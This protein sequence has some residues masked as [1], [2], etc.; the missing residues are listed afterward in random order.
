MAL[1]D[2][3]LSFNKK[4]IQL[5]VVNVEHGIRGDESLRDSEFVKNYCQ[6]HGL[7]LFF[8]S[9]D[10]L[11]YA[12]ENSLSVEQAARELRLGFFRSL[13]TDGKTDYVAF[14]HHLD[15]VCET[16]LMRTFRGTGVDGLVGIKQSDI[17][18][19]PLL[20]V[21]RKQI[22]DYVKE[23]NIPFIEDSTNADSAY[24]RNFLRNEILPRI[25]QRWDY[26]K[27][28]LT[29]TKNAAEVVELLDSLSIKPE[30]VDFDAYA[31]DLNELEKLPKAVKKHSIRRAVALLNG[32]VDFER[33]NLE[34]VLD[35][36]TKRNGAS[37][38]L[39]G[40][41]KVWKEYDKLTFER[42]I[43]FD[44]REIPFNVGTLKFDT[45]KWTIVE[46]TDERLRFDLSKIPKN[47]VIRGM[48][49]GDVFCKFGGFTKPLGD[50]YTDKKVPLRL[51]RRLPVIASDNEILVTVFEISEKVKVDRGGYTIK[52]L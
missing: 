21:T 28:I 12:K 2:L 32:G 6:T 14:A 29:L 3:F 25:E 38:D 44:D 13:I 47:A 35:L 8:K 49:D 22:D 19:R 33:S 48:K 4:D 18:L 46:R 20:G 11:A 43:P 17:F 31:L 40:G 34:C 52:K 50:F 9:F 42:S 10:S 23:N 41:V 39:A 24:S 26:R 5:S 45:Q 16:V 36:L 1:V 15:D 51:R 27:G 7:P 30:R 37:L